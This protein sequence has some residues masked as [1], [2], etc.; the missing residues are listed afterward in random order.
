MEIPRPRD[1]GGLPTILYNDDHY[2]SSPRGFNSSHRPAGFSSRFSP[3]LSGAMSIPNAPSYDEAPPPLPPPRFVP[4]EGPQPDHSNYLRRE[5]YNDS[6]Y[7][8]LGES[9]RSSGSMYDD[10]SGYKSR[11]HSAPVRGRDEGYASLSS[12]ASSR[13]CFSCL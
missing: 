2:P 8:S 1:H 6:V 7:G 5:E 9:L 3:T 10:R 12:F 4:V 11:D 13:Y